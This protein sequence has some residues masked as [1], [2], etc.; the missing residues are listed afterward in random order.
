MQNYKNQNLRFKDLSK[1]SQ[2]L[3]LQNKSMRNNW[4]ELP[5][6]L[7]ILK[8]AKNWKQKKY[9]HGKMSR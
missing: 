9:K 3:W 6:R 8:I 4:R 2:K 7:R 5:E 1:K